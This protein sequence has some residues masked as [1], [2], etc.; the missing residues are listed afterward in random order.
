[1]PQGIAYKAYPG[2]LGDGV[3]PGIFAMIFELSLTKWLSQSFI[4]GIW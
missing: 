1:M 2:A 3:D 4:G